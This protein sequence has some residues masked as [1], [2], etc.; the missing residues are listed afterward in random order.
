MCLILKWSICFDEE[1]QARFMAQCRPEV[2]YENLRLTGLFEILSQK[3]PEHISDTEV[4]LGFDLIAVEVSGHLHSVQ[5]QDWLELIPKFN[6]HLNEWGLLDECENW[7]Q[8]LDFLNDDTNGY[9]PL[10]WF[11]VKV[12]RVTA[13]ALSS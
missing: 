7:Q 5:C 12:K 10:P 1:Q 6:L 4:F 13:A 8:V 3:I 2:Q 9:E 11:V